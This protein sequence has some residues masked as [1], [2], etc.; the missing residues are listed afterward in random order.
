VGVRGHAKVLS[1]EL[2]YDMTLKATQLKVQNGYIEHLLK[3]NN[4]SEIIKILPK[5]LGTNGERWTHW[6]NRLI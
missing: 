6:I 4:N 3:E 5:L 2:K 1:D